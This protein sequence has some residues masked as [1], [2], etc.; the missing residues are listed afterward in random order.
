VTPPPCVSC[1]MPPKSARTSS[2]AAPKVGRDP[3]EVSDQSESDCDSV[4][5]SSNSGEER[6]STPESQKDSKCGVCRKT[7]NSSDKSLQCDTCSDWCHIKCGGVNK[8]HYRQMVL[9]DEKDIAIQWECPPCLQAKDVEPPQQTVERISKKKI[10]KSSQLLPV[11]QPPSQ[12]PTVSPPHSTPRMPITP[13][14]PH[15]ALGLQGLGSQN[16]SSRPISRPYVPHPPKAPEVAI[17]DLPFYPVKATL[18]RPVQLSA[19]DASEQQ[20]QSLAFYLS[21]EQAITVN[22]G[23]KVEANGMVVYTMHILLRFTKPSYDNVQDDDFP[24]NLCLKVNNKVCPLPNP[25]PVPA[26]RPNLEA[27]R[28]PKPLIITSLC[29]L[30]T[31]SCLNQVTVSYAT[32]KDG[33]KHTVSVYLVEKLTPS[34]LLKAMKIKGQRDPSVTRAV[35]KSKLEDKDDEISTTSCKVSMACPLGMARMTLPCR[36]STCD[37]LQCFDADLYLKMNEKKPKWVCPVCNRPAYFEHLFLDGFYIQLLLSPAFK[38]LSTNDII[39]NNDAS[40]EPVEETIEG[41]SDSEDEEEQRVQAAIR[42]RQKSQPAVTLDDDDDISVIP[43]TPLVDKDGAPVMYAPSTAPTSSP[44]PTQPPP[45][46]PV[47]LPEDEDDCLVERSYPPEVDYCDWNFS[48]KFFQFCRDPPP[49]TREIPPSVETDLEFGGV[50]EP[51]DSGVTVNTVS[52]VSSEQKNGSG[53]GRGGGRPRGSRGAKTGGGSK[54]PAPGLLPA[55]SDEEHDIEPPM[56]VVNGSGNA[57]TEGK[58]EKKKKPAGAKK[59]PPAKKPKKK[60]KTSSDEDEMSNSDSESR[61]APAPPP[62]RVSNRPARNSRK[63]T[64]YAALEEAGDVLDYFLDGR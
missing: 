5:G 19:K 25:K 42:M 45:R 36:A 60:K 22:N 3:W 26:N 18:L 46:T 43:M 27:K 47:P 9:A 23:R 8:E 33:T 52:S 32:A 59:K 12:L 57:T 29:K 50:E 17:R 15:L 21:P 31:K 13:K 51:V 41:V 37:H 7:V 55:S 58:A 61:S 44:A 2:R 63:I 49:P 54:R 20:Q 53:K 34:D 14:P 4:S 30:N 56:K 40:W 39:L 6:A 1:M 28:P 16:G 64:N 11:S 48:V 62:V 38:A 10:S 35:I 24:R